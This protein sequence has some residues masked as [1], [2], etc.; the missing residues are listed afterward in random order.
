MR[1][2]TVS[3]LI[4]DGRFRIH[5]VNAVGQ[6]EGRIIKIE[7]VESGE[8]VQ[9]AALKRLMDRLRNSDVGIKRGRGSP[10]RRHV[11]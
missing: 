3:W 2:Q 5:A 10:T 8:S 9:G 11:T 4:G 7:H 6:R 1:Q